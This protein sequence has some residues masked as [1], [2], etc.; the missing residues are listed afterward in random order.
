M[1]SSKEQEILKYLQEN[2]DFLKKNVEN[3]AH[4]LTP[5]SL[6]KVKSFAE[7]QVKMRERTIHK[8]KSQLQEVCINAEKN[9][10]LMQ[11]LVVFD[12]ELM[13]CNTIEAVL[14]TVSHTLAGPWQLPYHHLKIFPESSRL[15]LPDEAILKEAS[16]KKAIAELNKVVTGNRCIHP[17]LYQWFDDGVVVESFLHLP[18]REKNVTLGLLLIGHTDPG[19]F[20]EN[21]PTDFVEW[22]AQSIVVTLKRVW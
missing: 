13:A 17:A 11:K 12:Q 14:Q 3:L 21:L 8:L 10:G 15:P 9:Y 7:I 6:H 2:P 20:A 5:V 19:Y 4:M 1:I 22:L 16:T 18:L